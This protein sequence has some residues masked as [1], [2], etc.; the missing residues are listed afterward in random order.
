MSRWFIGY[1]IYLS[2][3]RCVVCVQYRVHFS[4]ANIAVHKN[5][6]EETL[7]IIY[8]T[9][10]N[11]HSLRKKKEKIDDR[12]AKK[13]ITHR[14]FVSKGSSFFDFWSATKDLLETIWVPLEP[15][16]KSKDWPLPM[17]A[18]HRNNLVEIHYSQCLTRKQ[19]T[20]S[21]FMLNSCHSEFHMLDSLT[22]EYLQRDSPSITPPWLT[23]Q[24]PT[25]SKNF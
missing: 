25:C 13:G 18:C 22:C 6:H 3:S 24:A 5:F 7:S 11:T 19:I 2:S 14:Y 20:H 16:F 9:S 1:L 4:V 8:T 23:K 17:E 10:P 21:W 15:S 12:G